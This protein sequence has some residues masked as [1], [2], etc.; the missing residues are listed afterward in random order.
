MTPDEYRTA[1]AALKLSQRAAA[2]VLGVDE[3]T[4]RRYA[5]KGVPARSEAFVR[6]KLDGW[7]DMF[8]KNAQREEE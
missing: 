6:D 3:R 1:I 7:A 5:L 4:S 2:R 8:A